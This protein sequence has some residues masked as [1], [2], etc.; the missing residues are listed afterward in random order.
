MFGKEGISNEKK[1]MGGEMRAVDGYYQFETFMFHGKNSS[2][3][4]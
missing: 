1:K 3:L 2:L 4:A